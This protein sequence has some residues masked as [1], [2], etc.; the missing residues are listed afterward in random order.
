MLEFLKA[1]SCSK[2]YSVQAGIIN[3]ENESSGNV[4]KNRARD[5]SR[6]LLQP[7]LSQFLPCWNGSPILSEVQI[8]R[9]VGNPNIYMKYSGFLHV[10]SI[11]I[12]N[13]LLD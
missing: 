13:A 12:F 3:E 9:E 11:F 8:S 1:Q 5:P 7:S 2:L 6:G 10:S 4:S